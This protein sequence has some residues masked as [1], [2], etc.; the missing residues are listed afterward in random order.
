MSTQNAEFV[1]RSSPIYVSALRRLLNDPTGNFWEGVRSALSVLAILAAIGTST[2]LAL[3][4]TAEQDI[5]MTAL[6]SSSRLK[7]DLDR[8]QQLM[9]EEHGDLYTLIG[10]KPFYHR[11]DY[12]FH[13]DELLALLKDARA[14]CSGRIG[15]QPQLADLEGMLHLNAQRSNELGEVIR[16][17]PDGVRLGDSSLSEIDACF[18]SMMQHVVAARVQADISVD[19]VIAESA[20]S[21]KWVSAVLLACGFIAAVLLLIV[22]RRSARFAQDLRVALASAD[23]AKNE[24]YQSKQTLEFVLDHVPQGIAWKDVGHRYVGGNQIFAADAGLPDKQKLVGLTDFDLRWGDDPSAAQEEDRRVMAGELSCAYVERRAF[25]ADGQ[26]VWISE[27]KVPLE[28]Q[29]GEIVGVL[30]AYEHI[31]QRRKVEIALRLQG[32]ALEASING[33][34][35]SEVRGDRHIVIFAN[36]AFEQM[37]G[38]SENDVLDADCEQLFALDGQPDNWEVVRNALATKSEANTTLRSKR[39][40]GQ[41]YWNHVFVAPVRD[42]NNC[43]THHVG[44]MT[45]VTALVDY[46]ERLE[47]QAKYDS[48][49]GL[50]NRTSLDESLESAILRAKTTGKQVWLFFLDLDRFKEVNDSLGHRVGDALLKLVANR[51]RGLVRPSDLVAR[52]GGDEFIMVI[53]RSGAHEVVSLLEQIVAAMEEPFDLEEREL[54]VEASIGISSYPKD[55][56]DS[57]TLLRNADAAMYSA[58]ASGRN[59]YQFYRPEFNIAAAERL[60]MSTNLRRAVKAQGLRVVYQPQVDMLT[61][62]V[63]GA[64]ALVRWDDEELGSVSPAVFIPVAEETG[65]IESI[66]EWVLRTACYQAKS[67]LD[68]GLRAIRIS[69]NVSPRQLERSNI[70]DVVRNALHDACL[71]ASSL[72]LEVTEGALMRNVEDVAKTLCELRS[73]GVRIAID[74]F[75]TGYSSLSYLKKFS[76]DRIKIDRAFV[77]EVGMDEGS[78]ALA[79]AV[80]GIANALKFEVLAE[81]VEQDVHRSFLVSH[82]C[83]AAQGFLFSAPTSPLKVAEMLGGRKGEKVC[84]QKL[85][86]AA[87]R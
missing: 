38:Y 36:Q 35:I 31:T 53:E 22:M 4:Q 8:F 77:R 71:P 1:A 52:Y 84:E 23:L 16:D 50:P 41:L 37:T 57:D 73:L 65:L 17:H 39:K 82:G 14:A 40:D 56:L 43:V 12:R 76:V 24:L 6:Q 45:D 28:D 3:K 26:E 60:R 25:G 47:H 59:G 32:R 20:N 29:S 30:R 18:Y 66:G 64:E 70:V 9:L 75:G 51:L 11:Q 79:L 21:V 86:D 68:E 61:G 7:R 44:V 33:I 13:L 85:I 55:G 74:D 19:F 46:R 54:Y 15:C 62:L 42:E 72:E 58:K 5:A 48:L 87:A 63:I 34:I 78:E 49:T 80:I 69:V 27:T 81:G 67:W 10:T 2:F 83:T